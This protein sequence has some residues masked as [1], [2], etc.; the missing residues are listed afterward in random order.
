MLDL[1][2]AAQRV[3]KLLAG[4]G[5]EQL[6]APT[7]CTQSSL[8]DLVDHVDGLSLAFTWAAAKENLEA[9]QPPGGSDA[10]RLGPDWRTRIP[11]RLTALAD[12]WARPD[13]WAGMTRAGGVDLPGEVA[14]IVALN[15]LVVHGWD[16]SRA[17]AQPYDVTDA[18]AE[19]CL[20]FV[21]MTAAPEQRAANPGLFGPVVAVPDNA[22]ALDRLIGLTGRNPH[23][24]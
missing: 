9:S 21:S 23:G 13:A 1:H 17:S 20:Q 2:P 5:D 6:T 8:G 18:E 10:S 16:I 14:G 4:V 22:S 19:A 15:E 7:P 12:A 3:T 11:Q 24:A